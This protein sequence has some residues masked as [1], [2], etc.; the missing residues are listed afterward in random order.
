MQEDGDDDQI[1]NKKNWP[2]I[3]ISW[4]IIFFVLLM[5]AIATFLMGPQNPPFYGRR[6]NMGDLYNIDL[7]PKSMGVQWMDG[8]SLYKIKISFYI[9]YY[10]NANCL[11]FRRQNVLQIRRSRHQIAR[12]YDRH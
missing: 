7:R 8:N 4:S 11:F 12:S 9:T 1:P 2:S 5:V 10:D 3:I 6:I